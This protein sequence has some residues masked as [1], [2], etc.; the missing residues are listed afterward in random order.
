MK[1]LLVLLATIGIGAISV[2]SLAAAQRPVDSIVQVAVNSGP[3]QDRFASGVVVGDG[4]TILTDAAVLANAREITIAY[5]DGEFADAVIAGIQKHNG[6]AAI[7]VPARHATIAHL[8]PQ[9]AGFQSPG[10]IA[11]T[12][13]VSPQAFEVERRPARAHPTGTGAELRWQ[14]TPQPAADAR[15]G[16]L[17][18]AQGRLVAVIVL[19]GGA[20]VGV[21]PPASAVTPP[22]PAAEPAATEPPTTEPVSSEP[23]ARES[24]TAASKTPERAAPPPVAATEKA[25]TPRASTR[26]DDASLFKD[27][28]LPPVRV[29]IR[30]PSDATRTAAPPSVA[31]TPPSAAAPPTVP[32]LALPLMRASRRIDLPP[33]TP[34]LAAAPAVTAPPPALDIQSVLRTVDDLTGKHAYA[35][36]IAA[37][38][39]AI[40]QHPEAPQLY[41]HL[42]LAYWNK[43]AL[44]DDGTRRAAMEKSPYHKAVKAFETFLEKAPHDALAVDARYRLDILRRLQYGHGTANLN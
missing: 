3:H 7:P 19:E 4:K 25:A 41:F 33:P 6:I 16:P 26:T 8:S 22:P 28:A 31:I 39:D 27:S 9:A 36:A 29:V 30:E 13:G 40:R 5:S 24:K 20:L 14:I 44:K 15:G 35:K 11:G 34:T 23:A 42:G 37:V 43:A 1:R 10:E 38:E 12:I 32:D 21:P 17:F 2:A 18:D